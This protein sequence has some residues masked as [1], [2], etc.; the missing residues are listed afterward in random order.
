MDIPASNSIS[1]K[2]T[3]LFFSDNI[4]DEIGL[5]VWGADG[6]LESDARLSSK[7]IKP[8]DVAELNWINCTTESDVSGM[9]VLI[10]NDDNSISDCGAFYAY[11]QTAD[12]ISYDI[13]VLAKIGNI[14]LLTPGGKS[15]YLNSKEICTKAIPDVPV[16]TDTV[17]D[18]T[19]VTGNVQWDVKNGVCTVSVWPIR[20]TATT[21]G[22]GKTLLTNLPAPKHNIGMGNPIIDANGTGETVGFAFVDYR[23]VL[24]SHFYKTNTEGFGSFSY[25]V[26]ES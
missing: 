20:S 8:G 4:K 9:E 10:K 26:K 7:A 15:A 11:K 25:P 14:R 17:F 16:T 13:N 2:T 3:R 24:F 19:D 21:A 18:D 6:T 1:G 12:G 22:I 5:Q 23:G